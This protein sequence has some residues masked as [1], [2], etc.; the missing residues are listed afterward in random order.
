[1]VLVAANFVPKTEI[2]TLKNRQWQGQLE[3]TYH[4]MDTPTPPL[5]LTF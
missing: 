4:K 1:M 3:I 5:K 2:Q